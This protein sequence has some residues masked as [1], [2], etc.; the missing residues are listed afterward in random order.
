VSVPDDPW[1]PGLTIGRIGASGVPDFRAIFL[2][3]PGPES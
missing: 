2:E 1:N 3:S